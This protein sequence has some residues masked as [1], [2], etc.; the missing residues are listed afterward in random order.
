MR[1]CAFKTVGRL[2]VIAPVFCCLQIVSREKRMA[3]GCRTSTTRGHYHWW[4][5]A[6]LLAAGALATVHRQSILFILLGSWFDVKVNCKF[7]P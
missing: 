7:Q 1:V 5:A 4:S 3:G 6:Q 2:E